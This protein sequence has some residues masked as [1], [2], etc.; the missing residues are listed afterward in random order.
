VAVF[1]TASGNVF[2]PSD[3]AL[4][5]AI[6]AAS[7]LGVAAG[8]WLRRYVDSAAMLRLLFLL[9][10]ISS[11]IMLGG[12]E[13]WR[14]AAAYGVG[15]A[16]LTLLLAALYYRPPAFVVAGEGA[17]AVLNKLRGAWRGSGS[18]GG[19]RM[20]GGELEDREKSEAASAPVPP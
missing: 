7:L 2:N 9:V 1:T 8:T 13:S 10:F 11:A 19:R 4:Y 18:G 12:L 14:V 17:A 15:S 20:A 6:A 16:A 5:A 3:G